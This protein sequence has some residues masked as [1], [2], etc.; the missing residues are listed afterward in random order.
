M[1][2]A[3][4]PSGIYGIYSLLIT[5]NEMWHHEIIIPHENALLHIV[6]LSRPQ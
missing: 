6:N 5:L 3:L 2:E 4:F 1:D